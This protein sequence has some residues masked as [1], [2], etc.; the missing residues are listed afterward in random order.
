MPPPVGSLMSYLNAMDRGDELLPVPT[1]NIKTNEAL[2][3]FPGKNYPSFGIAF[4]LEHKLFPG[5]FGAV[6]RE[7]ESESRAPDSPLFYAILWSRVITP[8]KQNLI[9]GISC[10]GKDITSTSTD[11]SMYVVYCA[12]YKAPP[13]SRTQSRQAPTY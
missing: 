9:M 10:T 11:S 3:I 12:R 2:T 6:G 1:G 8:S 7:P 13:L 4:K 5:M